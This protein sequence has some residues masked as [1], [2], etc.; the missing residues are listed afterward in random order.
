M[1]DFNGFNNIGNEILLAKLSYDDVT[2][3]LNRKYELSGSEVISIIVK[4]I[5]LHIRKIMIILGV[6]MAMHITTPTIDDYKSFLLKR[7]NQEAM[8]D[9][10][11]AYIMKSPLSKIAFWHEDPISLSRHVMLHSNINTHK[12]DFLIFHVYRTI[13]PS[14]ELTSIGL[15][16]NF[17]ILKGV[18]TISSR[19]NIE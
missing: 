10:N 19:K 14:A 7:I 15:L 11:V 5:H 2:L 9:K 17:I 12:I 16:N 18:D 6:V 3:L 1:L 8:D 4:F 13:F